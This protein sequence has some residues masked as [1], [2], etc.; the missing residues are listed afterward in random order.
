MLDHSRRRADTMWFIVS[1]PVL[2]L[3]IQFASR[4]KEEGENW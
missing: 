1:E 2:H 3:E 4:S